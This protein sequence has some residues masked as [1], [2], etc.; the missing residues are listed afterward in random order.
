MG[1]RDTR[2]PAGASSEGKAVRI[3]IL[4]FYSTASARKKSNLD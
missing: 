2:A 4:S 1:T 3:F